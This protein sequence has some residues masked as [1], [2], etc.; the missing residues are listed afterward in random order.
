MDLAPDPESFVVA[1][2]RMPGHTAAEVEEV[3]LPSEGR[4]D[5]LRVLR[6]GLDVCGLFYMATCQRVV[7]A[8]VSESEA[9]P[10]SDDVRGAIAR[11]RGPATCGP[12]ADPELYRGEG[13]VRHL[14]RI[15]SAFE[16]FVPG[17]PQVLGQFK[18]A[19]NSGVESRLLTPELDWILQRIIRA[20]K[21][22]R[23]ET[24]FF[25]G[26]VSTLPLALAIVE[27]RLNGAGRAAVVGSGKIGS[28]MASLL[29]RKFRNA[30]LHVVSRSRERA[31]AW[32]QTCDA[33]PWS[34]DRFL[35]EPPNLD[36]LVLAGGANAPF[37]TPDV[38][39]R[40]LDGGRGADLVVIDLGLP[41]NCDPRIGNLT[42]IRLVQMDDLADAA[43]RG[44]AA[45]STAEAE[46]RAI[47][48]EEV[49]RILNQARE[50]SW[51]SRIGR[52]RTEL[53][54]EG[55]RR[56]KAMPPTLESLIGSDPAFLKWYEQTLKAVAHVS[57]H[58]TRE[59]VQ[60]AKRHGDD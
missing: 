56:L 59:I 40:F 48:E 29:S 30:E 19:Y 10:S 42:G 32:A 1:T 3:I 25:A 44:K 27:T 15:A 52:L 58:R 35:L 46:A 55:R 26:K 23:A 41:R 31:E 7:L 28:S 18:E 6:D 4:L 50:S 37:L 36:V 5:A 24:E 51:G 54:D 53:V 39:S 33:I 34:L 14:A 22:V 11:A 21:R 20:A 60:E 16:S 38:A 17:E 45:R 2:W 49:H 43:K 57:M 9:V 13:A 8:F 47:L 12:V